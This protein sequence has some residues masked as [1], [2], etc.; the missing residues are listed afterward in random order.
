MKSILQRI[1]GSRL[2]AAG[3]LTLSALL[4]SCTTDA[5]KAT[6]A[7]GLRLSGRVIATNSNPVAGVVVTLASNG[8]K[9]TTDALGRFEI[10]RLSPTSSD[11]VVY[12]KS[13]QLLARV[14]VANWVDTTLPDVEVIQRDISGLLTGAGT[15]ITRVEG[16]VTGDGI[17]STSP[18]TSEF[19]YNPLTGNYSGFVYFPPSSTVKNYQVRVKIYGPGDLLVGASQL[20]PFTSFAGNVTIPAFQPGNARP[21]AFAGRDTVVLPGASILLHGTAVDSFGTIATWEWSLD[22]GPFVP[23]SSGDVSFSRTTQGAYACILRVTDNDGNQALDTLTVGVLALGA[24]W[25]LRTSTASSTLYSVAWSPTANAGA[26]LLVAAGASGG[27]VA[28]TILTSPDGTT[29]TQRTTG[30]TPSANNPSIYTVAWNGSEFLAIAQAEVNAD[31]VLRSPDGITWTRQKMYELGYILNQPLVKWING[32]YIAMSRAQGSFTTSP[33]GV[34]WTSTA[35][36][37]LGRKDFVWTGSQFVSV[38]ENGKVFTSPDATTWTQVQTQ[39]DLTSSASLSSVAWT[40]GRLIAVGSAGE[41]YASLDAITW[42]KR[43]QTPGGSPL[44][45][46]IWAGNQ[47]VAAGQGF[48]VISP[49]SGL[50]WIPKALPASSNILSLT[51]TGSKLVGVGAGGAIVTSP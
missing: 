14:S 33:D 8:A 1:P 22:G 51:W 44:N 25:T 43:G 45:T 42:S 21:V 2:A 40:G 38:G 18:V 16:V 36:A 26:G 47:A 39:G 37:S 29:W 20:V 50:S 6:E 28:G 5:D 15:T 48:V 3:V 4:A 13:G 34:T 10:R 17:D 41:I 46:V 11:T 31:N 27:G 19:Y 7:E 12:S 9:D 24:N 32:K 35:G 23:S 49:D 30:L